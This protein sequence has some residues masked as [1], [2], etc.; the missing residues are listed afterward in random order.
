MNRLIVEFDHKL[1]AKS[2][3]E[4]LVRESQDKEVTLDRNTEEVVV[5]GR[6]LETS[7]GVERVGRL[8]LEFGAT[9]VWMNEREP[10]RE[11]TADL[12]A[13]WNDLNEPGGPFH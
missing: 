8:A 12:L 3:I 10:G 1:D 13:Q 4:A 9:R 7:D 5:T 6:I 11:V 2:F